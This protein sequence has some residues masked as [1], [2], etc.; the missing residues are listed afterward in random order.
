MLNSLVRVS[1]RVSWAVIYSPPNQQYATLK[2][3]AILRLE[4]EPVL[5]PSSTTQPQS[6]EPNAYAGA[7]RL[8]RL[9]GERTQATMST[10]SREGARLHISSPSGRSTLN[11]GGVRTAKVH[12]QLLHADRQGFAVPHPAS[13]TDY[14][15]NSLL[16]LRDP[17]CLPLS[18]FTHCFTLSSKCFSIFHHCTCSLSDSWS[19]LAFDGVYHRLHLVL[20]NKATLR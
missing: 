14:R 19:Y 10:S 13:L 18:G 12:Q 9:T 2:A 11:G 8:D 15:L 17:N 4:T 3:F 7:C 1:R 20:A 6:A 16:C 5:R